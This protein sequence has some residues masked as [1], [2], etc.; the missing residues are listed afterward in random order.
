MKTLSEL[1]FPT[2]RDDVST[3]TNIRATSSSVGDVTELL[4][5]DSVTEKVSVV[6]GVSGTFSDRQSPLEDFLHQVRFPSCLLPLI[7]IFRIP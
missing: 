7:F 4:T 3:K 1:W 6:M 2:S 5:R